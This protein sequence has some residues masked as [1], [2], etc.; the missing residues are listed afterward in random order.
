M[1]IN[2]PSPLVPEP[3][4]QVCPVCRKFSYSASGIHPQCAMAKADQARSEKIKLLKAAA[5]SLM[6]DQPPRRHERVCPKC[7][8]TQHIRKRTCVCGYAFPI[9]QRQF[10][11]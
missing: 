2:K 8:A 1:S 9:P 6:P 10:S 4:R 5:E 7:K 11:T 3:I